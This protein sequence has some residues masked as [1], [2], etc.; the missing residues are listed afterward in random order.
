MASFLCLF[1]I[2]M[3]DFIFNCKRNFKKP[4][5]KIITVLFKPLK[6]GPQ[7]CQNGPALIQLCGVRVPGPGS[8]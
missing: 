6:L 8:G 3:T 1:D 5:Y 2:F 7:A 4:S